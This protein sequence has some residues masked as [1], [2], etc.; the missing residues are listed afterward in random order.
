MDFDGDLTS[1]HEVDS[2]MSIELHVQRTMRRTETLTLFML[3]G[4]SETYSDK[5]A[6]CTYLKND[7][8][9]FEKTNDKDTIN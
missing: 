2:S 7:D 9:N 8:V 4:S 3:I 5:V 6:L 1:W